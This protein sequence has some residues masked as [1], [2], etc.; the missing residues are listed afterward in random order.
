MRTHA[1][2]HALEGTLASGLRQLQPATRA[3]LH[4]LASVQRL[5]PG[6]GLDSVASQTQNGSAPRGLDAIVIKGAREH[7]LKNIDL[8]LPRNRLIVD[9]GPLRLGQVVARFR[10]DLRRR[11]AP[12][13]RVALSR[14]RASFSGQME[15]PDVDYI[16]GLSPAISIDQKS[17][18][19]NP[20]ST[21][22]T[23]TEIYDYLRLLFA[24]IG[25][26][27]C[28]NC[29]REVSAQSSEQIVD[30][31]H[32][33]A[34]RHAHSDCSRRVIRGRKGEYTKLFEEIGKEGFARVRV[35]GETQ[36]TAREDRSR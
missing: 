7:N 17:T 13:R 3:C 30:S 5:H 31:D 34:R 19:R 27:H 8:T 6:P 35:D 2:T 20:R 4:G 9:H 26:P 22:G 18:S 16:E 12:L 29:G 28:Y 36:G 23:V 15:K 11:P 24:R 33:A 21:V 25:M 1:R 32:G 10:H 14:T